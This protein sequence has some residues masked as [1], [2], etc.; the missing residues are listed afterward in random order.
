MNLVL[1][2]DGEILAVMYA[3]RINSIEA[4]QSGIGWRLFS[5][6]TCMQ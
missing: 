1:T 3:Q 5:I 6:G 4:M 2:S